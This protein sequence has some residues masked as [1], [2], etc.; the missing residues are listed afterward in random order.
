MRPEE[1]R[2]LTAFLESANIEYTE[3]VQEYYYLA[4]SP[5]L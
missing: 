2:D 4:E 5:E 3:V 1:S